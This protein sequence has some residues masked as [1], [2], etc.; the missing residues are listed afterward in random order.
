MSR[1]LLTTFYRI[2]LWA[3]PRDFR[4]DV[5]PDATRLFVDACLEAQ[6]ESGWRGPIRRI[7]RAAWDVPIGGLTARVSSVVPQL[8]LRDALSIVRSFG[9]SKVFATAA[10]LTVALGVGLNSV[11]FSLFDRLLLRPL[12][13][14]EPDRLV[15]I[16]SRPH[17]SGSRAMNWNVLLALARQPDLFSGIAYADSRDPEP[18]MTSQGEASTLWLKSV[19][20]N[21]LDV[22]GL[23]PVIGPGFAGYPVTAIDRPVLLSYNVWQHRYGGSPDVLSLSWTVRD[24]SQQTV[25][26]RVV[27]VLPRDF[28]LPSS[29]LTGAF[30]GVYGFDPRLDRQLTLPTEGLAPFARLAPGVSLRSARARVAIFVA[31]RFPHLKNPGPTGEVDRV[32]IAPLQSG[33]ATTARPYVWLLLLGTWAVL[34]CT[35]L[36]LAILLLTWTQAR[37]QDAG[38]RLALGASPRRLAFR[39]LAESA[40]LC[41]AGAAIGWVAYTWGRNVFVGA[42]PPM[43][44]A[45]ASEPADLRVMVMTAGIAL[46]IAAAAG[47]LPAIRTSRASPLEVLRTQQL[48]T[49][50]DR[51]IGGPVLLAVQAAFGI[52]ILVGA[53]ATVPGILHALLKSPGFEAA[54]LHVIN[55]PTASDKTA[56]DP[57]EQVRRGREVLVIARSLPG[58]AAASLSKT[59]PLWPSPTEAQFLGKPR[60]GFAFP[61]RVVPVDGDLFETQGTRMVA[62]RTFVST[63]IEQQALVA[64]VNEAAAGALGAQ[65]PESVLGRMVT[66]E[67]GPRVIVGV[68]EDV[69]LRVGE[70][71]TPALFLPLSADEAYRVARDNGLAY[72]AYQLVLR[73]SPGRLPDLTLLSDGVRKQPWTSP[74]WV[75]ASGQSVAA[76]VGLDLQVPRLLALTFG[77][78]GGIALLLQLVAIAGLA[79]FEIGRR[80]EE[81]TVRLALGATPQALRSRLAVGLAQPVVVGVLVG[82]PVSWVMTTLLARS[83]STVN[84]GAPHIYIA[85]AATMVVVASATAWI[86]GWRSITLRVSE[87]LR[88]S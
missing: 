62:G 37:R 35:C 20:T 87:L 85:A 65:S 51:L 6:L 84:A 15:Q 26:W 41:G 38:L 13:F 46:L 21:T 50:A 47:T 24:P 76:R 22:L 81:M 58:V 1:R 31:A 49:R 73:M 43:L 83:V 72:N 86:P 42:L 82:L 53:S 10:V 56:G 17:Q 67:D 77:T 7:C 3:Y 64:I 68:V 32:T 57:L 28:A 55:V 30:D 18:V 16:Y 33:V 69:R 8:A 80:R 12:P 71:T 9:R 60:K 36:T 63:E 5:G 48:T 27:G 40:F 4:R 39:A 66:T 34:G 75:G 29:A 19:S 59:H 88:T 25:Q 11:V 61:G 44:Q 45:Y 70:A 54:D 2:L 74:R 23:R 79:S 52:V 14:S 78:L